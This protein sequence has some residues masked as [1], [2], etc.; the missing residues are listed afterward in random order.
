MQHLWIQT[1]I[2]GKSAFEANTCII[3]YN[4]VPANGHWSL[5]P[6][7]VTVG[8]WPCVTDISGSPPMGSRPRRG[9]WDDHALAEH[10]RRYPLPSLR[11]LRTR[12]YPRTKW[13]FLE[14]RSRQP[15]LRH[16]W[17][18]RVTSG[19][20]PRCDLDLG[21]WFNPH[22]R[23]T[24]WHGFSSSSFCPPLSPAPRPNWCRKFVVDD[25]SL[26]FC[27][28]CP[29]PLWNLWFLALCST[30]GYYGSPPVHVRKT[31]KPT[32]IR[33][34]G[35]PPGFYSTDVSL[36]FSFITKSL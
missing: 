30:L 32:L 35:F 16:Q 14:H 21:P 4:L 23:I 8:H 10:G 29:G 36:T 33:I 20:E 2:N 26:Q 22:W 12:M 28:A 1:E 17:L 6:G 7:K 5:V 11:W 19:L 24:G 15:A 18:V 34:W 31:S 25:T 13:H 27:R 9:R 3:Q